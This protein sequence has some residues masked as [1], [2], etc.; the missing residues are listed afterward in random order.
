MRFSGLHCCGTR[1]RHWPAADALTVRPQTA[2]LLALVRRRGGLGDGG[3]AATAVLEAV[4]VLAS[5]SADAR[6]AVTAAD[7]SGRSSLQVH[8]CRSGMCAA[9][10]SGSCGFEGIAQSAC[11]TGDVGLTWCVARVQL[12]TEGVGW[13]ASP[14]TASGGRAAA[15]DV[16]LRVQLTTLQL[17]SAVALGTCHLVGPY[18]RARMTLM[19]PVLSLHVC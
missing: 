10:K 17:V 1:Q 7:E 13:P 8:S 11:L 12:L 5:G 2:R 14:A 18:R 4:A 15:D 6:A 19:P 9:N 16:E 3:G